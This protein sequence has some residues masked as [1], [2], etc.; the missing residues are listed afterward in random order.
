MKAEN[1]HLQRKPFAPQPSSSCNSATTSVRRR[2][3]RESG[4]GAN[5]TCREQAGMHRDGLPVRATMAR[6]IRQVAPVVVPRG[7]HHHIRNRDTI[8]DE[9]HGTENL[10]AK[11]F[12]PLN[13]TMTSK[14]NMPPLWLCHNHPEN[15][16]AQI[17]LL[18]LADYHSTFHS[19]PC[20]TPRLSAIAPLVPLRTFHSMDSGL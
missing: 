9:R 8:Y 18:K 4:I 19:A 3:Q 2:V 15:V 17:H 13:R 11:L 12:T 6:D 1:Y 5:A 20:R 16:R 14:M 7:E 10:F